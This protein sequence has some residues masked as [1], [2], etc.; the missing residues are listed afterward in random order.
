MNFI[1]VPLPVLMDAG[2]GG[3]QSFLAVRFH[4]SVLNINHP[5]TLC[6]R[7]CCKLPVLQPLCNSYRGATAR[8]SEGSHSDLALQVANRTPSSVPGHPDSSVRHATVHQ[9]VVIPG[10]ALK[11]LDSF[12]FL[13]NARS[14][15]S[16]EV[17]I[18]VF[19]TLTLLLTP[20]KT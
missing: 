6:W 12:L 11:E 5:Q 15:C 1:S 19:S 16:S 3:G 9:A 14:K 13:L 4:S 18:W 10:F 7:H 20:L 2:R 17:E 8:A